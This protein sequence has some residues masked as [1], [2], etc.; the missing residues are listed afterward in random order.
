MTQINSKIIL[1]LGGILCIFALFIN[2]NIYTFILLA[3]LI[4]SIVLLR[5]SINLLFYFLLFIRPSLDI[6]GDYS[7]TISPDLPAVN[8]AGLVAI[9]SIIVSL[10]IIHIS[11]INILSI[12]L[13][14]VFILLF[15]VYIIFTALSTYPITSINELIRAFSFLIMYF[16]GYVMIQSKIDIINFIKV[17]IVSSIIPTSVGYF[18]LLNGA[19][20]YTNPGFENRI[21]GTFGHPNVLGYFLLIILSLMIYLFFEKD[22]IKKTIYRYIFTLYGFLLMILLISTFTRGAWI[23]LFVLLTGV[24]I[25]KFTRK[26]LIYTA[27]IIPIVGI[28]MAIYVWMQQTIWYEL[29]PIEDIPVISRIFGLFSGDPSDSI[30]WRQVMWSDMYNK[31]LTRPILGFGTGTIEIIVEEV[32]GVSLGALE[33]HNDYIKSFVEMGVIGLVVYIIFII[34]ILYSLVIR[35]K[36]RQDTLVLVTIFIVIA[37]YLSSI[38]DNL[39]RQ[40]AVMWIFFAILGLVFK[41]HSIRSQQSP[42][43]SAT[44]L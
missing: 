5:I 41:Y 8:I 28:F 31:A 3:V 21:A 35:M 18:Q 12:P 17:V 26:T 29:T 39:L 20:L 32:R 1:L 7:M 15:L 14:F 25:I 22:I 40:T 10:M 42:E 13:S 6:L 33:V 27:I 19:G 43:V 16:T 2:S 37:I 23:G 9:I 4:F 34:S 38:W 24:S 11:K 44:E 30:I 36:S